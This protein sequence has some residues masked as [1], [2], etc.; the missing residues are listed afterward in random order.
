M[1]VLSLKAL[2]EG[3]KFVAVSRQQSFK[4]VLNSFPE[5]VMQPNQ[6]KPIDT[7]LEYAIHPP[8][9]LLVPNRLHD[10]PW[11][12]INN[13]KPNS[14]ITVRRSK[15]N[16]A[17]ALIFWFKVCGPLGKTYYTHL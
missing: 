5:R 7:I 10:K 17:G 4:N 9:E 3:P 16:M 8:P 2:V 14:R 1:K 11:T 13:A 12:S 6:T 15:S